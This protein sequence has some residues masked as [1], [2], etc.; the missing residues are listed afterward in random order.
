MDD[1][2]ATLERL[3]PKAVLQ[4]MTPEAKASVPQNLL[5]YDLIRISQFPFNVGRE[6]RVSQVDGKLVR[7]ER[8]KHIE[9]DS[10]NDLYLTDAAHPLNIS[11]EHFRIEQNENGY[12]LV[13][14]H[15]A[16]GISVDNH[17]IAGKDQGG[18]IALHDGD[19]IAVGIESTP[20]V[21]KFITL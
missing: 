17:R 11:R 13:D 18:E 4:A 10:S 9:A 15:S 12:L 14:R 1:K 5:E 19:I 8:V 21:F 3:T 20:Y 16:C 7:T 2:L 6:S